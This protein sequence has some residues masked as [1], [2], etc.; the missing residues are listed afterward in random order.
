MTADGQL[1]RQANLVDAGAPKSWRD[2]L[3]R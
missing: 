1:F 2:M 3:P